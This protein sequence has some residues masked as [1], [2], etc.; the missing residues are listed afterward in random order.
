MKAIRFSQ[1]GGPE[2]LELA[3]VA[4]PVAGPGQ[5]LIRP[6][7]IG[8]NFIDTYHR[9]GLYP[10]PLPSGLGSE[11]A[12]V[13]EAVGDGVTRFKVGDLA[14]FFMVA[15]VTMLVGSRPGRA[16]LLYVPAGL[17]GGAA[18]TRTLAWALQGAAFAAL[19]ITVEVVVG[20]DQVHT[21]V[22]RVNWPLPALAARAVMSYGPSCLPAMPRKKLGPEPGNGGGLPADGTCDAPT[23]PAICWPI[24]RPAPMP[25]PMPPMPPGFCAASR[26]A[27]AVW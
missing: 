12:G 14:I 1:T 5:I 10:V 6:Q 21:S 13:V 7:A 23:A 20:L 9:S 19:F 24:A 22:E 11:G 4:E 2:V 17:I 27:S 26:M 25:A 8:I 16:G 15:G 3:D 18:I